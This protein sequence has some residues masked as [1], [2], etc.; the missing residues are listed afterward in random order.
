MRDIYLRFIHKCFSRLKYVN[1]HLPAGRLLFPPLFSST[2][3]IYNFLWHHNAA[4]GLTEGALFSSRPSSLNHP[5]SLS[6]GW[7]RGSRDVLALSDSAPPSNRPLQLLVVLGTAQ[8]RNY[9]TV[10]QLGLFS[11]PCSRLQLNTCSHS[12]VALSATHTTQPS[13]HLRA[14]LNGRTQ[15]GI[16]TCL[17]IT[18]GSC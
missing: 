6:R 14:E 3:N 11:L 15:P 18:G 12:V 9:I 5:R 16:R 10:S 1:C 17:H 2:L 4:A 7:C 8:R 13:A